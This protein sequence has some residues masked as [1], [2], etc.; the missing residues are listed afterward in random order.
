MIQAFSNAAMPRRA[1]LAR[2]TSWRWV[3]AAILASLALCPPALAGGLDQR[4]TAMLAWIDAH[5]GQAE[6]L[7]EEL[8]DINSG[9]MN[10]PGV[11]TVGARLAKEFDALGFDTQ[12]VDLPPETQ[13]AGDLF[14]RREGNRGRK[15]L[16][17]GHLDTVFE[18]SDSFQKFTREGD[19]AH[20]PGV[21]DM[22]SGDLVILYAIKALASVG[23]LDGARITVAYT[24]DE[25]SPGQPLAVSRRDLIAAGK[26]ADVALGFE[27]GV[28]EDGQEWATVARRSSSEWLL[29]VTGKRAHS[30]GIFNEATGAG[31]IFEA[32]RILDGFY[33]EVRGE[34]Y[35]TFNAGSIVGGTEVQYDPEETRGSAFGK[36]NV[37]PSHV[38]V[39]GGL[40]TISPEQ[41]ER[42]REAMRQVVARHLPH[43]DAT[44]TFTDGYPPMAPT[45][46]NLQLQ[47]M[48]SD[49]NVALGG[50]P[51][52]ALDPGKR[53][54]ADISF[55]APYTDALAGL[56]PY[57]KGAHTPRETLDL[58]SF[59]VAIKRTALLLYRLTRE[60]KPGAGGGA[61]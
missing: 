28:R 58:A 24:G 31:A 51:M 45:A 23:A 3:P 22:K 46:G 37:V 48:L 27:A 26:W 38:I 40:R 34:R 19:T 13:R 30:A 36:T 57:G 4:E 53:G 1:P 8:V 49:I 21:N 56:G 60:S 59:P 33:N 2:A 11:R 55:V 54:A 10:A 12:W 43:T 20:G 7:L 47:Q 14:A 18:P 17:I 44:I 42:A 16:M 39:Q 9:T 41:T 15:V 61:G 35:L 29:D 52:P 32:A 5:T 6:T 50:K 25:E